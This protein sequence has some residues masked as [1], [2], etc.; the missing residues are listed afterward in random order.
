MLSCLRL[1]A[2]A[3]SLTVIA[4]PAFAQQADRKAPPRIE[5]DPA[6]LD[7]DTITIGGGVG[8]VPS[9]DGSNDYV[10]IPAAAVRGR[11]NGIN[12]SSRGLQL[13]A[14][15][16]RDKSMASWDLM[17]GPVVSLN[18]NRTARIVDARV[19]ALGRRRAAFEVG[20]YVGIGKTGV[21]T[22]PYDRLSLR[23]N[24]VRDVTGVHNSYVLTPVIDYGTP[25]SRSAYIGIG[26][27]ATIVGDSY[28]ETYFA[29]DAAGA[30]RSGLPLFARPRGGVKNYT[31]NLLFNYALSGDLQHGLQLFTLVSYSRL[32]GDF[33]RSPLTSVAGN[34]NQVYSAIGLGYTF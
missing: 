28:A 5:V 31:A 24:Y 9:Y 23:V 15:L 18:L 13:S 10:V 30:A 4:V 27:S 11:V 34:P 17:L 25:I 20:G 32:Q 19:L 21:I 22:S 6:A 26:G 3:A 16:I 29:V 8:L 33:A 2:T 1:V 14:D 7:R 12:F